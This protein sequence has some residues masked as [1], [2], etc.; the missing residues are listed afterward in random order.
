[1]HAQVTRNIAE[2]FDLWKQSLNGLQ[3]NWEAGKFDKAA[4]FYAQY[5]NAVMNRSIKK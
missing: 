2:N 4:Y 3:T 5:W 1:V